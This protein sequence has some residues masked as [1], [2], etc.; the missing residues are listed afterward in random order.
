[1]RLD[2]TEQI[3][4]LVNSLRTINETPE[5]SDE[6]LPLG[7][8]AKMSPQELELYFNHYGTISNAV[9]IFKEKNGTDFI[10]GGFLDSGVFVN[11]VNLIT[12]N[13]LYPI[14][15]TQLKEGSVQVK[16][17]MVAEDFAKQGLVTAVYEYIA[18]RID[19]VSDYIQFSGAR[20]LWQ[21]LAAGSSVYIQVFDGAMNDYIR[22]SDGS[23]VIYDSINI[24][25]N[26]IW[27]NRDK[28]KVLLIASSEVKK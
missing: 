25:S 5:Y 28:Q 2:Y 15:P 17:S 7:V 26:I 14:S 8:V 9:T 24:D 22:D 18:N 13:K 27:G 19:L 12:D 21:S 23:V 4:K 1:M 20:R 3:R 6:E 11:I 10:A 16:Y